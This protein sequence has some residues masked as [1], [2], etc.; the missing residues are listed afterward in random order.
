MGLKKSNIIH[1]AYILKNIMETVFIF[2]IIPWNF[3]LGRDAE[4]NLEFSVCVLEL[5]EIPSLG[6]GR[7]GKVYFQ[8]EGKKVAFFLHL[9]NI[10]IA[11]LGLVFFCSLTSLIFSLEVFQHFLIR[12]KR[13][14]S[15]GIFG[16]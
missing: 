6:H 8:C 3:V 15:N 10:Q 7:G 2:L 11:A 13:T 16:M 9:L 12:L 4:N 1:T 14:D 5:A